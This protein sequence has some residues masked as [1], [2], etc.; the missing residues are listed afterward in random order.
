MRRIIHR[1]DGRA[2]VGDLAA[3]IAYWGSD[4]TRR[5]LTLDYFGVFRTKPLSP[6]A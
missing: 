5:R 2:P 4:A 6:A 1:F 3:V